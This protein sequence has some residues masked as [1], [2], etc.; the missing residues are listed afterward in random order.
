M[1]KVAYSDADRE[2]VRDDL[3]T[4]ALEKMARQ[5]IQHTTV[6][7]IYRSVGISRT[8]F[9]TFFP[10]KEDLIVEALYTQQPKVLAHAQ[11]LMD[12]PAFSWREGVRQFLVSCCYGEQ[13]GIAVMTLEEQQNLFRRLSPESY[14]VFREKQANLFGNILKCFGIRADKET[15]GLFTNLSLTVMVIRRAVPKN[16]P[17]L[18][19]EAAD[20]TVEF[21]INAIVDLLEKMKQGH[22]I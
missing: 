11:R 22:D 17:F 2:R 8:F 21:Q 18:V 6:E 19:P 13:S 7:E 15:I 20:A 3:I 16:L 14:Q 4:V 5:G 12:D 9:Y 1:P 10:T